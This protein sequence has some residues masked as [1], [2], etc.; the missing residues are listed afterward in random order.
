MPISVILYR[1]SVGYSGAK[2]ETT[3]RIG[4]LRSV[5]LSSTA[6]SKTHY[7]LPSMRFVR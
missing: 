4:I 7:S 1:A 5:P 2:T 6:I 3:L